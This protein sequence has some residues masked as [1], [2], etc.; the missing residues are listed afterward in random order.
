MT[1]FKPG[2]RVTYT[3]TT[4][5]DARGA[6]ATV[7]SVIGYS[8]DSAWVV[9]KDLNPPVFGDTKRGFA[10]RNLSLLDQPTTYAAQAADLH[11]RAA[12]LRN[13]RDEKYAE[14]DR[15]RDEA[16]AAGG[17]AYKYERAAQ[18]LD[19]LGDTK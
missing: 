13:E 10:A 16:E 7:V 17:L 5:M 9:V 8:D 4:T 11:R 14:A 1:D 6:T 19:L 15:L 18:A 12:D 2:D 3:G